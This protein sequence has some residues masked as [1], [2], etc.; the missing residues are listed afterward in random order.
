M[1]ALARRQPLCQGAAT[2]AVKTYMGA[3]P[4]DAVVI[5]S[6]P[7]RRQPLRVMP[8]PVGCLHAGVVPA[9]DRPFRADRGRPLAAAPAAWPRVVA[10][11]CG[12]C[13][14]ADRPFTGGLAAVGRP[15]QG[16]W[17]QPTAP[18][19]WSAALTRGL[20]VAMPGCSLQG[21]PSLRK[22]SKNA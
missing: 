11:P 3:T 16:A 8:L 17:S 20:A 22:R 12:C 9:I 19:R 21:L 5:G 13:A 4:T 14:A 18:C 2:P 10:A 1:T 15:L 6:H 7:C